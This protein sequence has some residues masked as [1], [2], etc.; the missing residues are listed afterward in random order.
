MR[1]NKITYLNVALYLYILAV[2]S[3]VVTAINVI[4]IGDTELPT[5]LLLTNLLAAVAGSLIMTERNRIS[6]G[7]RWS[8]TA[9]DIANLA[10]YGSCVIAGAGFCLYGLTLR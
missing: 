5:V 6:G 4:T 9:M 10:L 1:I 2:V 3:V 7:G 8:V